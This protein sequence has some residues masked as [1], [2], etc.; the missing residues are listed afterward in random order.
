MKNPVSVFGCAYFMNDGS[1]KTYAIL[2]DCN[3]QAIILSILVLPVRAANLIIQ[4]LFYGRVLIL[5]IG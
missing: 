4:G 2:R 1:Q 5:K 3:R